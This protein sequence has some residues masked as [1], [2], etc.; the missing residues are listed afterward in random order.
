MYKALVATLM[1][2][3][4]LAVSTP[5]AMAEDVVFTRPVESATTTVFTRPV[6]PAPFTRPVPS[7]EPAIY[8]APIYTPI[9]ADVVGFDVAL[10][11]LYVYVAHDHMDAALD[12]INAWNDAAG[13]DLFALVRHP[14]SARVYIRQ[15]RIT[16]MIEDGHTGSAW[17][18]P[19]PNTGPY[20]YCDITVIAMTTELHI[21]ELGHCLGLADSVD[22]HEWSTSGYIYP[23]MT[24]CDD[25]THP[26]YSPYDGI[27]SYCGG[28]HINAGD[29]AALEL[30][31]Y[32]TH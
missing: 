23:G 26:N 1:T 8:P 25:P 29:I 5:T 9:F 10:L 12:A 22:I 7:E 3:L 31:G 6:E 11:P 24:V 20:T 13:V 17:M 30:L 27:M 18:S 28:R 32:T 21:H 16:S 19:A 15:G 2:I 4:M 14:A